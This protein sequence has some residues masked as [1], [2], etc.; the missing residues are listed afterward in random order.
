MLRIVDGYSNTALVNGTPANGD[1]SVLIDSLGTNTV[2]QPGTRFTVVGNTPRQHYV[3][4][5]NDNE[6]QQLPFTGG[7]G[8]FKLTFLGTIASPVSLQTTTLDLSTVTASAIQAALEAL[9]GQ[10]PGDFLVTLVSGTTW[11]VEYKGPYA[12]QPMGLI[13]FQNVTGAAACTP[14]DVYEGGISHQITF[15]PAFITAEGIPADD[16]V[17]TFAGHTLEILIGTGNVTYNEHK[18]LVYTLDRGILSTVRETDDVP[19]DVVF[20]FQWIFIT[21]Q[22]GDLTPSIDDALKNIGN[23]AS[24]VTSSADPCE[25]YA[26]DIE[27]EHVP[28]C[29]TE[30]VERITFP[31][32]RWD[33]LNHDLR[34]A[35]VA[36]TGKCNAK[37]AIVTRVAVA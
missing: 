21:A 19:M 22:A 28:P 15:T 23:A 2:F 36:A 8:T 11:N 32:F 31:D 7:T 14:V 13:T 24:W 3:T 37:T 35:Q 30:E 29:G 16:A 4:A 25:P 33:S 5:Q 12:G 20:D 1:T 17:I 26:V 6:V 27:I 10:A 9:A 18:L 34:N